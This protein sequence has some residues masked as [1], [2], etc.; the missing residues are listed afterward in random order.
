VKIAL[1]IAVLAVALPVALYIHE[2]QLVIYASQTVTSCGFQ[3]ARD[4]LFPTHHE[5]RLE[6]GNHHPAWEDPV[7]LAIV[8]GGLALAVAIA[9]RG[10]RLPNS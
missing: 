6:V 7:A 10:R 8:L 3:A 1:A 4:C 5:V 9:A 2:R